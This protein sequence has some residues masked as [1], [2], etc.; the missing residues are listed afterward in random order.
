MITIQLHLEISIKELNYI[1]EMA[2]MQDFL[3]CIKIY[4]LQL[5][6]VWEIPAV[7]E[8]V[9]HIH[10]MLITQMRK[11]ILPTRNNTYIINGISKLAI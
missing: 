6:Y 8:F 11:L 2:P 1:L 9:R 3:E 7:S 10:A 5:I 4:Q